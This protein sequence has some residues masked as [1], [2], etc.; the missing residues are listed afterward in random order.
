[1]GLQILSNSFLGLYLFYVFVGH[2]VLCTFFVST[3]PGFVSFKVPE[4][5]VRNERPL[6]IHVVAEYLPQGKVEDVGHRMIRRHLFPTPVVHLAADRVSDSQ[7]S[8]VLKTQH[9][10]TH[11]KPILKNGFNPTGTGIQVLY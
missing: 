6:L 7:A 9:Y 3:Y 2:I 1:M 10:K 5:F 8:G 4:L 11:E